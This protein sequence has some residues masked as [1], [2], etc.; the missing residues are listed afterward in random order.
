MSLGFLDK[1]YGSLYGARDYQA[2]VFMG[3]LG[4]S[5]GQSRTDKKQARTPTAKKQA[6]TAQVAKMVAK[7]GKGQATKVM[8]KMGPYK[9]G[10]G[11]CLPVF[12][13][14]ED[15][16]GALLKSVTN[17]Q[18]FK[19]LVF[20]YA[21]FNNVTPAAAKA[22]VDSELAGVGKRGAGKAYLFAETID[23]VKKAFAQGY[24][25]EVPVDIL[26]I[27]GERA[28]FLQWLVG[29]I[30]AVIPPPPAPT[31]AYHPP[32]K[33]SPSLPVAMKAKQAVK[34]ALAPPTQPTAP[35]YAVAQPASAADCASACRQA[36]QEVLAQRSAETGLDPAEVLQLAQE[37]TGVAESAAEEEEAAEMISPDFPSRPS[38][39][40]V[41]QVRS[42][43]V[44]ARSG[45]GFRS[46]PGSRTGGLSGYL[47]QQ[48]TDATEAKAAAELAAEARAALGVGGLSGY[49]GRQD[50]VVPSTDYQLQKRP[51]ES[52]EFA[53]TEAEWNEVLKL[54]KAMTFVQWTVTLNKW[55][56]AFC[57]T[58]PGAKFDGNVVCVGKAPSQQVKMEIQRHM[59]DEAKKAAAAAGVS[60][61]QAYGVGAPKPFEEVPAAPKIYLAAVRH[62]AKAEQSITDAAAKAAEDAAAALSKTGKELGGANWGLWIM[63]GLIAFALLGKKKRGT[64][65]AAKE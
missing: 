11:A 1:V 54:T 5:R 48:L 62:Q 30:K 8:Q 43:P 65:A 35:P 23:M 33:A 4:Q 36:L 15:E 18:A 3:A 50:P 14:G 55:L 53:I 41:A 2:E 47:G 32:P 26:V 39:G 20:G 58:F 24:A 37:E 38:A 46:G 21:K 9:G 60:V 13:I 17:D 10:G 29:A 25:K 22:F 42:R 45:P 40:A 63:G 34:K 52:P 57:L 27:C 16:L 44:E 59:V 51:W 61:E 6:R 64:P 12:S 31:Q 56:Q 28:K 49:L 7:Y 19:L